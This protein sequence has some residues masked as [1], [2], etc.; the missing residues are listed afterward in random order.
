MEIYIF[1]RFFSNRL[2]IYRRFTQT[3]N[4][5]LLTDSCL[6]IVCKIII[7]DGFRNRLEKKRPKLS[8]F[9]SFFFFGSERVTFTHMGN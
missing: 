1:R 5:Y 9:L 4:I 3:V 2:Y 8:F 7:R 6:K